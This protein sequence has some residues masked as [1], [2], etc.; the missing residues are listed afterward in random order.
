M[1]Q[2]LITGRIVQ[3][4]V[5]IIILFVFFPAIASKYVYQLSE[6]ILFSSAFTF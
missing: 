6:N 5:E 4:A 1:C 2:N 3:I